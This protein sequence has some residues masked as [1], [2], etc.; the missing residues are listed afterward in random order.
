MYGN[1]RIQNT[2]ALGSGLIEIE[3]LKSLLYY[4]THTRVMNEFYPNMYLKYFTT[5]QNSVYMSKV[6]FCTCSKV[7]LIRQMKQVMLPFSPVMNFSIYLRYYYRFTNFHSFL[8]LKRAQ[9]K[10]NVKCQGN[11]TNT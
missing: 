3:H 5:L 8:F 1:A 6:A 9:S 10:F 2:T 4:C 11:L 7:C